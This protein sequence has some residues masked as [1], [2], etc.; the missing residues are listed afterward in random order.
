MTLLTLLRNKQMTNVFELPAAVDA[1]DPAA[2]GGSIVLF[3]FSL[4]FI[5]D[6]AIN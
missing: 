4:S 6:L 5:V 3:H 1:A 2:H